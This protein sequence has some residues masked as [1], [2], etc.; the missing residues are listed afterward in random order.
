KSVIPSECF[1]KIS[2]RLVPNQDGQKVY[3]MVKDAIIKR[4]PE[5]VEAEVGKPDGIGDAYCVIPPNREGAPN[6]YPEKLKK[7]FEAVE[8]CVEKN[9]ENPPIFLREGASIPLLSLLKK[10]TGL[11]SVMTGL[12]SP[13]DNLHAPNES[14]SLEMMRR[15]INYYEALFERIAK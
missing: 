10:E 13:L 9:F 2:V 3:D 11:D 7:I 15:A 5:G 8:E 4:C 12:F 14:F 1:C 6:P